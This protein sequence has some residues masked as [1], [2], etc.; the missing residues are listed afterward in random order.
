MEPGFVGSVLAPAAGVV[1]GVEDVA[2]PVALAKDAVAAAVTGTPKRA[3]RS[4]AL[5]CSL[6]GIPK[7]AAR[8][9]RFSNSAFNVSASLTA[10]PWNFTS[11]TVVVV[12]D[13]AV[14]AVVEGGV[15]ADVA[16]A[17]GAVSG[18]W[19]WVTGAA[20]GLA[21]AG[22]VVEAPAGGGGARSL[23]SKRIKGLRLYDPCHND[24]L[25]RPS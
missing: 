3:A 24:P 7:R 15:V 5:S 19:V 23:F 6:R 11:P 21:G 1:E 9:L 17:A 16:E 12:V 18:C 13:G 20:A 14:E 4:T 8:F 22:V 25:G 10:P 2:V